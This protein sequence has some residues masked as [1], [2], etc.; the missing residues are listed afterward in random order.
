MRSQTLKL[1][2]LFIPEFVIFLFRIIDPEQQEAIRP[3]TETAP[4]KEAERRRE[5]AESAKEEED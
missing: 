1:V 3:E 5:I 4:Q 2:F